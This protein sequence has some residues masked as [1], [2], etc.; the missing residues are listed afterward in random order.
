MFHRTKWM[1][2]VVP[3]IA[4]VLL[5]LCS[6]RARMA[7]VRWWRLPR[8]AE[9]LK[10]SEGEKQALDKVFIQSR[11]SLIDLKSALHKERFELGIL[12]DKAPLD[13]NAITAQF[14]RLERA[15]AKVASER[16]RYFLGVR[17]TL[18]PERFQTLKMMYKGFRQKR[19]RRLG[20][21]E[22]P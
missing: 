14:E 18:G 22:R 7:P 17:R 10:L 3:V 12:M 5:P 16:F 2:I 19:P 11:R 1:V 15:R 4:W 8:V 13:E 6:A 20:P 21:F 9:G